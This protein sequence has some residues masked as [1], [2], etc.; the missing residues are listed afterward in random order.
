MSASP[1]LSSPAV[2]LAPAAA[3]A[4]THL[5]VI[6]A[7]SIDRRL[8]ELV[9]LRVSQINGCAFCLDMHSHA[10]LKMGVSQRQLNTLAGW[11][12]AQRLFTDKERAALAWAE[13]VNAVPHHVPTDEEFRHVREHFDEREVTELTF[14]VAAIRGWNAVNASLHTAVPPQPYELAE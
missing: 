12:E 6:A 10:L 1:R 14:L 7:P 8:R 11:R 13:A 3:K 5:S 2:M 9:N 4:L